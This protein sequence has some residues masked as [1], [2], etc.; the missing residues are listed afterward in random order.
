M[1]V[2]FFVTRTKQNERKC[3][4]V[5]N[6][7]LSVTGKTYMIGLVKNKSNNKFV[8]LRDVYDTIIEQ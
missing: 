1:Y 5:P 2:S 3:V 8:M 4:T 7:V 6:F